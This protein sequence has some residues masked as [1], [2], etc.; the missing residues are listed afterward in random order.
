MGSFWGGEIRRV[1][2]L[3]GVRL[4]L[5]KL[6]DEQEIPSWLLRGKGRGEICAQ[7]DAGSGNSSLASR[8]GEE[9]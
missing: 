8:W 4:G 9:G 2:K 6:E 5:V 3:E 7:I 1:F